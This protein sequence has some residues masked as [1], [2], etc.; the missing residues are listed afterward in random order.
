M[1]PYRQVK[2]LAESCLPDKM[3]QIQISAKNDALAAV[4]SDPY[5]SLSKSAY[6]IASL[7]GKSVMFSVREAKG[8][9][10]DVWYRIENDVLILEMILF[11]QKKIC[12]NFTSS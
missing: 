10:F 1:I 6:K 2:P 7:Y 5:C 4:Q 12:Q 8:I 3:T 9:K 11:H